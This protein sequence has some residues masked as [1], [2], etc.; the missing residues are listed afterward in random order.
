VKS[1]RTLVTTFLDK[2]DL[3]LKGEPARAIGYGAAAV[4]FIVVQLLNAR[5]ISLFPG[6]TFEQAVIDSFAALAVLV[7]IIE[8]IRHFVYSPQTYIED[9][10]DEAEAAH[11]V[12]HLEE[13]FRRMLDAAQERQ[14]A[15]P[16]R[17]TV[18]VGST[19]ASGSGDKLD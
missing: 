6:I 19:K 9:L 14:A 5:G 3:L 13:E 17:T 4:I 16:K 10:S 8:S 15:K 12:A 2:V 18:T 11:E 7:S 1:L